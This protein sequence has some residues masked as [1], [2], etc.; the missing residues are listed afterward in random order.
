MSC[1][2]FAPTRCE[3]RMRDVKDLRGPHTY[4]DMH[5]RARSPPAPCMH[6][7]EVG[8]SAR[9]GVAHHGSCAGVDGA[10]KHGVVDFPMQY[11]CYISRYIYV[12]L[13]STSQKSLR[14]LCS[15]H[16]C[17]CIITH[18]A[19]A[20]VPRT[21]ASAT[22]WCEHFRVLMHGHDVYMHAAVQLLQAHD[23]DCAQR[24][25]GCRADGAGVQVCV[26]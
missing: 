26:P 13:Y 8:A 24:S 9:S 16:I 4:A 14:E 6:M 22:A 18:V 17:I 12:H 7:P 2:R 21:L 1:R 10:I 15:M 20:V 23:H 5:G 3:V 19:V 25:R 11:A